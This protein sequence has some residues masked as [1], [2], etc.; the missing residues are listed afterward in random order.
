MAIGI[1]LRFSSRRSSSLHGEMVNVDSSGLAM[2]FRTWHVDTA[3][4][5]FVMGGEP[6][7]RYVRIRRYSFP[8]DMA[9]FRGYDCNLLAAGA[10]NSAACIVMDKVGNFKWF[11]LLAAYSRLRVQQSMP[12]SLVLLVQKDRFLMVWG[13]GHHG[14]IGGKSAAGILA[15][16]PSG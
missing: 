3:G 10:R 5:F 1:A 7:T 13:E 8:Q 16:K 12:S 4:Q 14:Q 11:F 6:L 15:K 2:A 9:A